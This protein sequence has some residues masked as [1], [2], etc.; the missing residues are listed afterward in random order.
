MNIGIFGGS[1]NPPHIGHV[2]ASI[3]AYEQCN[4][5]LLI[6][7]PAGTPPHKSLPLNTPEPEL[8][9]LMT[10]NA[11][12]T[13]ENTSKHIKVSDIEIYSHERNYTIDTV[14]K[15]RNEYPYARLF[16]FV[17]TDMYNAIDTWKDSA[18]LLKEVTVIEL[19]R[20]VI[21]IS[22]SELREMLVERKGRD[23]I[24]DSNYALIIKNRLYNAKPDW[25]WLRQK[26]YSMLDPLR[27]PHV[28]ACEKEAQRLAERWGVN[29]NDAREAAI[30]HDI[31]K[32][33]DFYENLCII[34][35]HGL[36]V[37][38]LG[39][40]EE[41]LLHSITGA[42]VA[43][44][45]FGASDTVAEAIKWHTTGK[46]GMSTL[47]KI[48]YIADYIE[49]TRIL[50]GI[51]ELRRL[52]YIDINVA[53]LMGLEMTVEDLVSRDIPPN[54]AT[55]EAINDFKHIISMTSSERKTI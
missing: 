3:S 55:I 4:L 49:E 15:I 31:T 46:A 21:P 18:E 40:N 35:K 54:I 52:A 36:S 47:E 51:D 14:L 29:P 19:P 6:V 33:L 24:A 2:K 39:K 43:Q 8:R 22:S 25:D 30:L 26:A 1:F 23:F 50:P 12:E 20:C 16:L 5:D 44:S 10:K 9:L 37:E 27:V 42:L 38:K 32:K 13:E 11:F 28:V 45:E 48:I 41:K 53:M 34:S 17:G 7:I